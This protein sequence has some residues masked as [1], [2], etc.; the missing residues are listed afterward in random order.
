MGS[1]AA[2][3]PARSEDALVQ[4]DRYPACTAQQVTSRAESLDTTFPMTCVCPGHHSSSNPGGCQAQ[5]SREPRHGPMRKQVC[6]CRG[7]Y[8]HG[9]RHLPLGT[10]RLGQQRGGPLNGT[11]GQSGPQL[12][13]PKARPRHRSQYSTVTDLSQPQHR[14]KAWYYPDPQQEAPEHTASGCP[15]TFS[16]LGT[17][18]LRALPAARPQAHSPLLSSKLWALSSCHSPLAFCTL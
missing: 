6:C 5:R 2:C 10:G 12:P 9:D 16:T 15:P 7:R 4:V 17:G 3:P 13:H 14:N 11:C 18:A 1:R 8:G